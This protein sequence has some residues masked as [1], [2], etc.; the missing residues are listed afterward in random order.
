[1][2]VIITKAS[3][4]LVLV[5]I[6]N[7]INVFFPDGSVGKETVCNAEDLGSIPGLGRSPGEG[8]SYAF[9]YSGLENSMDCIVRWVTKS[10]IR[11]SDFHFIL[12][13]ILQG[14]KQ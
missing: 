1:M 5:I 13:A 4:N 3:Y 10:W 11:L 9:Q 6:S 12:K 2:S 8:N 7:K 14:D